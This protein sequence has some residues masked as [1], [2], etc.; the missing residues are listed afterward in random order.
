MS[1]RKALPAHEQAEELWER[2]TGEYRGALRDIAA[3][4]DTLTARR[5]ALEEG[6][7]DLLWFWFGPSGRRTLVVENGWSW[8]RAE[9]FLRRT[10]VATLC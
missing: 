2:A 3:H 6:T 8:E 4:L 10:A 1:G 9:R 5:A 7:A